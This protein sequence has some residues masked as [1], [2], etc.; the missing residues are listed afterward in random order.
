[1]IMKKIEDLK[2]LILQ[3]YP[4]LHPRKFEAIKIGKNVYVYYVGRDGFIYREV[5]FRGCLP[6]I[7]GLP[8]LQQQLLLKIDA[9]IK[10]WNP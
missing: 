4:Q 6:T 3:K 10:K 8:V 1:M 5:V 2:T 7:E 9:V